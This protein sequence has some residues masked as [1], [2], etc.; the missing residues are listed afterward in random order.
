MN[1]Y[2]IYA[3]DLTKNLTNFDPLKNKLYNQTDNFEA[4]IPKSGPQLS[5]SDFFKNFVGIYFEFLMGHIL[6]LQYGV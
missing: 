5:F 2:L 1:C 3:R 4:K 6:T